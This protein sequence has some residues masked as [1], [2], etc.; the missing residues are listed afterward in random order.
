MAINHLFQNRRQND[1]DH[2]ISVS[3]LMAGLM[4]VFLFIAISYMKDIVTEKERIE[5]IAVTWNETQNALYNDLSEEF[6]DDL[7]KWDASL[8]RETLSIRFKEPSVLFS[9]GEAVL[10]DQ[11]K[12]ILRDFFPRYLAVLDQ[13]RNELAEVRIEG[14]TS[15]AWNGA[16]SPID[17]YFKNMELSQ[18]R[19]RSVLQFVLELPEIAAYRTWAIA[20]ITANGL[21]SSNPILD[22]QGEELADL[23][24]RVEF[25][26]RTNAEQKIVNILQASE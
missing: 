17:A 14:H 2:W 13:Y 20:N 3:D 11:F 10:N 15:S 18:G 25:R 24:R 9:S 22:E 26:V 4:V 8:D 16:T 6:S 7:P 19:T 5:A 12:D 1:E 23:S 21:S